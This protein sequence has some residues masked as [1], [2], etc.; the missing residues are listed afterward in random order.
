M[1]KQLSQ[2]WADPTVGPTPAPSGS[3]LPPLS[4]GAVGRLYIPKLKLQWV[5]VEG[6]ALSDIRYGPGHYPG[7][8]MPGKVGNFAMAG[9]RSPG[10]FWDLDQVKPDDYLIVETRT[11]WYVYQVF[12]DQ[13]VTPTS[14]EVIAPTPNKAGVAP[15]QADITLTTCNPKWDNYQ[16]LVVHGKLILTTPHQLRPPELPAT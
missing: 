15:T 11:D 13:I 8:A 16:R 10:I 2:A 1:D 9:H 5:V 7:T 4:G 12:Q 14:V 3:A 6:V